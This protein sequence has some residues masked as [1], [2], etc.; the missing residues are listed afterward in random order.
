MS[1]AYD[2]IGLLGFTYRNEDYVYKTEVHGNII[3]ILD[4]NGNTVVEYYYDAWGNY[5]I[6][7]TSN[8]GLGEINPFRYRGY[9]YDTDMGLYYLQTR[10]YDPEFG[11]FINMD[12]IDKVNDFCNNQTII[13]KR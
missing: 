8:I 11:R 5:A 6:N 2:E 13:I 4:K 9:F 12:G 7:D 10:C 3:A 1:F